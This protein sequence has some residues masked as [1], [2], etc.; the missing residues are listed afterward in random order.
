MINNRAIVNRLNIKEDIVD[1]SF[2]FF[3]TVIYLIIE[4][5]RPMDTIHGLGLLRPGM[6]VT[7]L[8]ALSWIFKRKYCTSKSRQTRM[9]ALFI[10]YLQYI[11]LLQVITLCI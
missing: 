4:Y 5:G 3:L 8:L 2:W 11:F 6:I 9:I 10:F 1:D 7:I